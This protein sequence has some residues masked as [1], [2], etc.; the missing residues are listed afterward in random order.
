MRGWRL[1]AFGLLTLA[2]SAQAAAAYEMRITNYSDWDIDYVYLSPT[3]Y[4]RWGRDQVGRGNVMQKGDY[5]MISN[6]S[7][8][9]WDIRVVDEDGDECIITR[10]SVHS[11]MSW[12]LTN[13]LLLRC[14]NNTR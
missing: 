6:I 13:S 10:V 2:G 9:L 11:N 1:A 5:L 14:E 8:G 3:G 4:D 12:D 7:A